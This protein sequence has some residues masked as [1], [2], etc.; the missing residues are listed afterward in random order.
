MDSSSKIETVQANGFTLFLLDL[1]TLL[2]LAFFF[3][4]FVFVLLFLLFSRSILSFFCVLLFLHCLF[5]FIFNFFLFVSFF[6]DFVFFFVIISFKQIG[7]AISLVTPKWQNYTISPPVACTVVDCNSMKLIT[8]KT[9]F[10]Q[11]KKNSS[12]TV[13]RL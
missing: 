5:N 12:R 3:V 6:F 13:V 1:F 2:L 4:W 11:T 10:K 9:K 8:S 7:F